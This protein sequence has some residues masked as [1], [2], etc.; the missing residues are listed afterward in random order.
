VSESLQPL[1]REGRS[2][3]RLASARRLAFLVDGD[4]YFA[5]LAAALR[6]ARRSIL[7]AGW[8]I[9]DRVRL[10]QGRGGEAGSIP[11]RDSEATALGE[12]LATRLREQ[13]SLR[14]YVLAWDFAMIYAVERGILPLVRLR[15][16][17]R[18]RLTVRLDGRHPIGASHHQK[19]VVIDD[20]LAFV[21]GLD[22]AEHRWDTPRHAADE[23]GRVDADGNRYDPFHDV[24][25]V[26]EGPAAAALGDL[27]RDRWKRATGRRLGSSGGAGSREESSLWPENLRADLE[28]VEVGLARTQPAHDGQPEIREV[29][30][31]WLDAISASRRSI[32]VENQYLTSSRIG[33]AL[34]SRL[35]EENGPEV[36]IVAPRRFPGW[37][38]QGTVGALRGRLLNALRDAD[39]HGRLRVLYPSVPG[40]EAGVYVHA[41]VLVIDD[42]LVRVGSANL[43]NRSMGLDTECDLAVESRGDATR[44]RRIA[45]FRNRLLAEHLDREAGEVDATIDDEGGSL[46]AAVDR[47]AREDGRTLKRIECPP[48]ENGWEGALE[49]GEALADPES[50]EHPERLAGQF[51]ARDLPRAARTPWLRTAIALGAL[52]TLVAGW[53]LSPVSEALSAEALAGALAPVRDAAWAA[54]AVLGAYVLAGLAMVPVTL[55][56]V[57][58]SLVFGPVTTVVYALSGILASAAVTFALGRI[59]GRDL[60]RRLAGRRLNRLSRRVARRGVWAVCALRLLPVAPFSAVNMVA[61]VSHLG[62]RD[63]M[64]GTL[65]GVLPGVVAIAWAEAGVEALL[66]GSG[67]VSPTLFLGGAAVAA[68]GL[69]LLRRLA[70]ARSGG[71]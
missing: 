3:W 54:P 56:I 33:E 25:A 22:L 39:R 13:R 37:L 11:A 63:F 58:T 28:D 10:I 2:V 49:M 52:A 42:A 65:L 67:W 4:A 36:V 66:E 50:P 55:L 45:A 21:G 62:F 69:T 51:L 59:L 71:S 29:E 35:A 64:A 27:F 9:D 16:S 26:V 20:A 40:V 43:S 53:R 68:I 60:V 1:L 31:L 8:E 6:R 47:L 44:S 46:A 61:G 17:S 7:I 19:L 23:P 5:T 38:E 41:K 57:A 18:R 14:T 32:Y 24:Q 15:F 48:P 34:S 70:G 30:Q 12:I